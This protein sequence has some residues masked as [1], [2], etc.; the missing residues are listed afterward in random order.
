MDTPAVWFMLDSRGGPGR[1]GGGPGRVAPKGP[2]SAGRRRARRAQPFLRT[3]VSRDGKPGWARFGGRAKKGCLSPQ[4]SA[5][6]GLR[7]TPA[8]P[9]QPRSTSSPAPPVSPPALSEGF[10]SVGR[11]L[12]FPGRTPSQAAS[13]SLPQQP[14]RR[15]WL[16]QGWQEGAHAP[17]QGV[18]GG[19][20]VWVVC[21]APALS[22]QPSRLPSGSNSSLVTSLGKLAGGGGVARGVKALSFVGR[23]KRVP[24]HSPEW[25]GV[26]C[27]PAKLS[28]SLS[29][30]SYATAPSF[31]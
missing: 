28:V 17:L 29:P 10:T 7:R 15:A 26:P 13:P 16:S 25:E 24:F 30:S 19:G 22:S 31:A 3:G 8:P 6:E 4:P 18:P 20:S 11:P 5:S 23:L 14:L 2:G 21:G 9:L 27:M 12:A 1:S